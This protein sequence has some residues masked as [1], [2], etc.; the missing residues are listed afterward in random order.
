MTA[1]HQRRLQRR[2]LTANGVAAVLVSLTVCSCLGLFEKHPLY[3]SSKDE[4]R[5][6]DAD[7][8]DIIISDLPIEQYPLLSRSHRLRAV[9]MWSRTG[10]EIT[11]A[12]LAA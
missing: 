10:R 11:D 9:R 12:K 1:T 6:A 8:Q 2:P 3:L 7:T 5:K 4:I